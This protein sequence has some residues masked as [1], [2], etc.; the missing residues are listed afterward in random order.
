MKRTMSFLTQ[1]GRAGDQN[2]MS[3]QLILLTVRNRI[4]PV[5]KHCKP[6]SVA[7]MVE[8]WIEVWRDL[9]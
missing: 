4:D 2:R 1:L 6:D 8:H 5:T 3:E 9:G 7:Q